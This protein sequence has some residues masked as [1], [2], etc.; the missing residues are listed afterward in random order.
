MISFIIIDVIYFIIHSQTLYYIK[1][2]I[3]LDIIKNKDHHS[4]LLPQFIDNVHSSNKKLCD[5]DRDLCG[6]CIVRVGD[7]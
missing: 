7:V 4:K 6:Q 3:K 5:V 1:Y 2:F